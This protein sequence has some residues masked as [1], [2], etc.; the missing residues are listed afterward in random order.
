MAGRKYLIEGHSGRPPAGPSPQ[1]A[2]NRRLPTGSFP[3]ASRDEMGDRLAMTGNGDSLAELDVSQKLGQPR[4][5]LGGL[6]FTHVNIP[7]GQINQMILALDAAR[8][9]RGAMTAADI[10]AIRSTN[11]IEL[12]GLT[13]AWG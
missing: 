13:V 1:E 10:P 8:T 7:T 6:D 2:V 12:D 9:I 5:G 11:P 3:D 4:L